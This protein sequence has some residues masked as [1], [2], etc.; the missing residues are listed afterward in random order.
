MAVFDTNVIIDFLNGSKAASAVME[1]YKGGGVAITSITCY[2]LIK[3]IGGLQRD[4]LQSLFDN[5]KIYDIDLKSAWLAG[6]MYRRLKSSG[7]LLSEA[8]LLIVSAAFANGEMF[9]TQDKD[10]DRLK[11]RRIITVHE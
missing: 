3:G 1:K 2:E 6:E 9:V 10:F 8:D 11:D 4:L 5:V 7:S